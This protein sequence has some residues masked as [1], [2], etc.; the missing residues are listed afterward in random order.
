MAAKIWIEEGK[1]IEEMINDSKRTFKLICNL[2]MECH[3]L[4]G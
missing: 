2:F 4:N 3:L 1:E